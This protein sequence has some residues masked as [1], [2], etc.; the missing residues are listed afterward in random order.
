MKRAKI[1]YPKE[2]Y[3][4]GYRGHMFP[5]L[6]PFLKIKGYSDAERISLYG[7]SS[8]DISFVE[9]PTLADV[10]ILP[11]SWNYYV[12]SG[13]RESAL[14]FI[15]QFSHQGKKIFIYNA[16][17]IGLKIPFF[18]N[19]LIFRLAV[20]KTSRK[21]NEIIIPPFILDP[22]KT[23]YDS[24][25]I[26]MRTY[27]DLP[28]VG[29]C[30][31]AKTSRVD[32]AIE[33][34]K[35]ELQNVLSLLDLRNEE[36]QQF[37]SSSYFRGRVLGILKNSPG[38]KTNFIV[39]KNYRAGI[40]HDFSHDSVIE[41]FNNIKDSDYVFCARGSGNFS[42]RFYETLAMGRIPVYVN[43][44]GGLPL[45]NQIEWK[46]HVVWVEKSEINCIGEKIDHFHKKMNSGGFKKL[47]INN[48]KLWEERL[49][50]GP[51]FKTI[52]ATEIS[53]NGNEE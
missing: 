49:T 46:D 26:F 31:F 14:K 8:S 35:I 13:K 17:D 21:E 18:P 22:L 28:K 25:Q 24:R 2:L 12:I 5:L 3:D 30:G 27:G 41:F 45:D 19:V 20:N 43:T 52:L 40:M 9:D 29:F 33:L 51:Y 36:P 44:N 1:F 11:M 32:A 47:L 23:F 53:R 10:L 7:I 50:L 42:V 4:A 6:K 39:R 34:M 48:R 37:L 38:I 15:D 16:G